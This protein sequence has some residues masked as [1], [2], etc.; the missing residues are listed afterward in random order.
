MTLF[1]RSAPV[2]GPR[3]PLVSAIALWRIRGMWR[4]LVGIGGLAVGLGG[5]AAPAPAPA[6]RLV[7]V[8]RPAI[9][10]AARGLAPL[11]LRGEVLL[12][13]TGSNAVPAGQGTDG[14][15]Y[16]VVVQMPDGARKACVARTALALAQRAE[17]VDGRCLP[18]P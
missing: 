18:V 9:V 6:P 16:E 17:L 3:V 11:N 15:G 13:L 12:A 2:P 4:V 8:P 5:C 7:A 14:R 10:L 1:A